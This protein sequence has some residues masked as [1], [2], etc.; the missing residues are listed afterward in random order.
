M[1][2]SREAGTRLDTPHVEHT[3]AADT[4]AA[5]EEGVAHVNRTPADLHVAEVARHTPDTGADFEHALLRIAVDQLEHRKVT[6][7]VGSNNRALHTAVIL[8]TH[9]RAAVVQ[10]AFHIHSIH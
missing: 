9:R 5:G 7:A 1:R 10:A 4:A 8:R 6:V 2:F 3:T